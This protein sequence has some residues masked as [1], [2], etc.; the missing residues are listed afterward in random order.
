MKGLI[1]MLPVM[2]LLCGCESQ[3][4]KDAR[5]VKNCTQGGFST[6]QCGFLNALANKSEDDANSANLLSVTAMGL[7]AGAKR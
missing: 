5:F 2:A 6:A 7:A 3:A 1:I 4:E